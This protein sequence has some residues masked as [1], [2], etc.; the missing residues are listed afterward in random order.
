MLITMTATE[1]KAKCLEL[2]DKVGSGEIEGVIV[3]KRGKVTARL[4][5]ARAE[6][7][8]LTEEGFFGC[9]RGTVAIP[10]G[11]DLTAPTFEDVPIEA[12]DLDFD[13][14]LNGFSSTQ[15]RS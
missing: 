15:T 14:W 1:F 13:T 12:R 5:A 7:E 9:M 6:A 3:T 11:A 2:I 4:G 10:E 8:P